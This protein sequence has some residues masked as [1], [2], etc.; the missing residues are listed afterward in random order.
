VRGFL[1]GLEDPDRE[2]AE[3]RHVFWSESGSDAA[4]VLIV[5]PVEEVMHALDGPV[6]TI[7]G[8]YSLRRGLVRGATRDPQR[9]L[10]RA[11]ACVLLDGFA[12]DQKDLPDVREVEV[13]IE[14]RTTTDAPRLKAAVIGRGDLD[15]IGGG[16]RL[17]QQCDIALQWGL[18][19]LD[20]E[21]LVRLPLDEIASQRT[22]GQQ[23]I[24]RDVLAGEDTALTQNRIVM[25][26]SLVRLNSSRPATG[27]APTFFGC[28]RSSSDVPPR[29]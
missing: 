25:P 1:E 2:A 15:E 23:G 24:A 8:Q 11:L 12:L 5:V 29:S 18:V 10:T 13:R 6:S 20:G 14:R 9:D 17:A 27:K 16:T 21:V 26:S 19:T 7:D 28:G 22:L 4:T 3:A